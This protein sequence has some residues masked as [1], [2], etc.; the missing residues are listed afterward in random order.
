MSVQN[1]VNPENTQDNSSDPLAAARAAIKL[2]RQKQADAIVSR[3][4]G[5]QKAQEE[6]QKA[7]EERNAFFW[8][9]QAKL[10]K[11][12]AGARKAMG[13]RKNESNPPEI[14]RLIEDWRNEFLLRRFEM[15]KR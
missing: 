15:D 1:A 10:D 2:K 6:Y 13:V 12:I 7:I 14:C 3:Q 8:E 5:K 4:K 9:E 11:K